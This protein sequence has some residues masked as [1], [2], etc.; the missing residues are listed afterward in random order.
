MHLQGNPDKALTEVPYNAHLKF[1]GKEFAS[2]VDCV[3][4]VSRKQTIDIEVDDESEASQNCNRVTC[5]R[6]FQ[7]S[8]LNA[9]MSGYEKTK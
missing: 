7:K 1:A 5:L 9:V 2:L 6:V 8:P 4:Y 3:D